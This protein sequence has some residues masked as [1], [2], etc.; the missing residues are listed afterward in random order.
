M[1]SQPGMTLTTPYADA[2]SGDIVMTLGKM[3]YK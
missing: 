2:S 1:K 3:F